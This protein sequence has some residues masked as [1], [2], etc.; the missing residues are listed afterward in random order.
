MALAS[1]VLVGGG[2][3]LLSLLGRIGLHGALHAA[4]R[5]WARTTASALD[6]E[7][8]ITGLANVDPEQRYVIVALHEGLIDPIAL[9]HLPLPL[10]FAA[11]DELFDW[12]ALGRYLRAT[13]QVRVDERPDVVSLRRLYHDVAAAF[14]DGDSLVVFAQGSVLGIEVAFRP[15]AFRIA[16]QLGRPVLPVVLAGSHLVWEHPFS[17]RVRLG[18]QIKMS[19]LPAIPSAGLDAAAPR[20]IE[21]T[22]K[23]L[24]L[25]G[26]TPVR[27]FVPERDGWWDG[28]R[29]DIDP[30][31]PDLADR[32]AAHRAAPGV[33]ETAWQ[34][35]PSHPGDGL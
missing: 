6:L 24:A 20:R 10:R 31:F 16:R 21:R 26:S 11:R 17:P 12:H 27:R 35:R 29:F 1:R 22:M 34:T 14:D 3:V 8:E 4:E 5:T 7:L 18:R 9:L 13:R 2:S 15:G 23:R 25:V 33:V 32:V 30:D 19:I 28:Y